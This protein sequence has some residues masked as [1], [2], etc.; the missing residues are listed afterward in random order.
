MVFF[1]FRIINRMIQLLFRKLI[2]EKGG[3]IEQRKTK[4]RAIE[5]T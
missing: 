5:L 4:R 1:P 3:R 2:W